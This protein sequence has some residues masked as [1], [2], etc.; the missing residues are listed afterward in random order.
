MVLNHID[1][2]AIPDDDNSTV[3]TAATPPETVVADL[4]DE[5]YAFGDIKTNS[6]VPWPGSTFIIR[7]TSSGHVITLVDGQ[8]ILAPI[9]G[10]GSIH[11]VCMETKGWLGFRNKAS[12]RLLGH[13]DKGNLRCAAG[14]HQGWENFCVRLRPEGGYVLLMT[15]FERLWHVGIKKEHGVEKLAK[16]GDGGNDGLVWEFVKV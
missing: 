10:R 7:S 6:S 14:R 3:C 11:W 9:G 5:D 12:G 8:I 16:I 4:M 15:H 2:Q 1:P 13:D